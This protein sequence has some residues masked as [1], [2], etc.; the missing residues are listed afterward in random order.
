MLTI[1]L[2]R[3]GRKN[4]PSFRVI[5]VDSKKG[6]KTGRYLEMVGSYDPRLDRIDLQ[7]ERIKHWMAQG[8]QVSG[9]V[10]NL[11][12]T[13]GIIEGKKRNVL[14]RKSPPKVE[15]TASA[16]GVKAEVKAVAEVPVEA[17]E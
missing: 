15:E 1:R 9:T 8:A 7:N 2:Q 12:I 17:G 14:P 10:H 3:R 16:T 4:D 13:K 5:V 6:P 11:L